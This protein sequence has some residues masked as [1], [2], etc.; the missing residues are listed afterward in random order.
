MCSGLWIS[1]RKKIWSFMNTNRMN[2][3]LICTC[4]YCEHKTFP[5]FR[6]WCVIL[7]KFCVGDS[8]SVYTM[9]ILCIIWNAPIA[10]ARQGC[11]AKC[12][13]CSSDQ[14]MLS[15]RNGMN[16]TYSMV[17]LSNINICMNEYPI[18][19]LIFCKAEYLI[20]HMILWNHYTLF[21][22]LK[23]TVY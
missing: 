8:Q 21:D 6:F 7:Q 22:L 10:K 2:V 4:M 12:S 14:T 13:K 23:C 9:Y 18:R 5:F 3:L 11:K 16:R 20:W 1:C 17:S 19:H 15:K